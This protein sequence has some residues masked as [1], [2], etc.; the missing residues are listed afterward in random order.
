ME[1]DVFRKN[2]FVDYWNKIIEQ[3]NCDYIAFDNIFLQFNKENT[4]NISDYFV[5]IK[6]HRSMGF[7]VY[8]KSFFDKYYNLKHLFNKIVTVKGYGP[9]NSRRI[10]IDIYMTTF[11]KFKKVVPRRQVC[12]QIVDKNSTTTIKRENTHYYN[13]YYKTAENILIEKFPDIKQ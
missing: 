12:R 7:I 10:P 2:N 3:K 11:S 8:F 6:S 4:V 5:S 9:V 1:D 13:D